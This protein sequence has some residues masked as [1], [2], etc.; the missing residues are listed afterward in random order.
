LSSPTCRGQ[1]K[2]LLAEIDFLTRYVQEGVT[3]V[4]AGAAPGT[5]LNYLA[6]LF[7]SVKKFV[8]VDPAEFKCH[9]NSDRIVILQQFF[10]DEVRAFSIPLDL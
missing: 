7:P 10:T 8:L 6:E 5:H 4:Y 9:P 2:L 1:R 3:V